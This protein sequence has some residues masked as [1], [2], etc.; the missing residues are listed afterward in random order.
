VVFD[1][2]PGA[3]A[4]GACTT[5]RTKLKNNQR[6]KK[7]SD[8]TKV[9]R[10]WFQF[11]TRKGG[12]YLSGILQPRGKT[13]SRGTTRKIE[14]SRGRSPPKQGKKGEERT[15]PQLARGCLFS[16]A[17]GLP[18]AGKKGLRGVRVQT[19]KKNRGPDSSAQSRNTDRSCG[20]GDPGSTCRTG[21]DLAPKNPSRGNETPLWPVADNG[22]KKKSWPQFSMKRGET[23]VVPQ[24]TQTR[25]PRSTKKLAQTKREKTEGTPTN[26]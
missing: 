15:S 19:I 25:T 17:P 1:F 24:K 14:G 13:T 21:D 8:A 16:Y 6:T 3:H 7:E 10:E 5:K 12:L 2:T 9:A 11:M 18:S 26:P 23:C 20:D 4:R 22:E